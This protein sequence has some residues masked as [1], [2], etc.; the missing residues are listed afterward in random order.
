MIIPTLHT[1]RLLLRAPG[2]ADFPVYRRFYADAKASSFYGGPLPADLAWRKLAYDVGHWALRGFGMW[3]IVECST[4]QMVGSCGIV[5]AE[6]WP[7]SELTWWIAPESRRRGYALEASEA[8][9]EWGYARS[10]LGHVET[11]MDDDNSAARALAEKLGGKIMA[12]EKFPDGLVRNIYMLPN[13]KE[14][15][16]P[17]RSRDRAA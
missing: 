6:G 5:W 8:A 12:R 7:R 15:V 17:T 3:S 9:I 14:R 16:A 2:G 10:G 1:K 11:H 4:G 13:S